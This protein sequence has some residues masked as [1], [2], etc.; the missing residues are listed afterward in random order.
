MKGSDELIEKA[1]YLFETAMNT[2]EKEKDPK[3][4]KKFRKVLRKSWAKEFLNGKTE[5]S[6]N[7]PLIEWAGYGDT[8]DTS[9]TCNKPSELGEFDHYHIVLCFSGSSY[10]KVYK[11]LLKNTIKYFPALSFFVVSESWENFG[12]GYNFSYY[13]FENGDVFDNDNPDDDSYDEDN[14][15]SWF[16]SPEGY[17]SKIHGKYYVDIST[18]KIGVGTNGKTDLAND[19]MNQAMCDYY[20]DTIV[21]PMLANWILNWGRIIGTDEDGFPLQ[22]KDMEQN[23]KICIEAVLLNK[24]SEQYINIEETP[25][26]K[27][28]LKKKKNLEH[29]IFYCNHT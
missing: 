3:D 28:A 26:I 19:A 6:D 15:N 21:N 27:T 4:L 23:E 1:L 8:V 14:G 25:E 2:V 13:M 11:E 16:V 5:S 22:D 18:G 7:R 29:C 20:R 24:E 10:T 9:L 17:K 12:H